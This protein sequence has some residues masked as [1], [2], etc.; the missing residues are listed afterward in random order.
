MADRSW[1]PPNMK[2]SVWQKDLQVISEAIKA[3]DSPSPLFSVTLPIWRATMETGHGEHDMAAVY[4]VFERM[5]EK[6][7]ASD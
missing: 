4:E 3:V 6:G 1:D 5:G 2:N 7:T